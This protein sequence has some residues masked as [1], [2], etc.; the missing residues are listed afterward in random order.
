LIKAERKMKYDKSTYKL[1]LQAALERGF[2]FVDF[3]SVSPSAKRR[4]IILRHDIDYSIALAYQIAE[5]DAS[6]KIRST[7]ALLLTSPLYNPFTPTNIKF[8]NDIHKLRHNIVLHHQVLP[9]QSALDIRNDI[10]REMHVMRTYYPYCQNVFVWHALPAKNLLSDMKIPGM[11]NAYDDRYVKTMSYI[12]DSVLRHAPEIFINTL[13][14]H[15]LIH[16]LLHPIIWIS[17]QND[18]IAII[19]GVLSQIIHAC[20]DE[21]LVNRAWKQKFPRG[22]P[23]EFLDRLQGSLLS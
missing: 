8:I 13:K 22:I 3:S 9:G 2:E 23:P 15:N 12:S 5:L 7:F 16:M 4:Q 11:I 19:A 17:E 10:I 1:I 21:F 18:M 20:D 14:Q 6:H